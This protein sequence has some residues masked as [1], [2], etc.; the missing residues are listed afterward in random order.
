MQNVLKTVTDSRLTAYVIW[1]PIFGGNFN[2]AAK[3]MA[4]R[5]ADK[6]VSYYKDP[7][8]LVGTLWEQVLKTG[9]EIAWDVYLLYDAE[10]KWEK[11]LPQPDFW[12]HQLGG[13]TIAPRLDEEKF[14]EEVKG[15]LTKLDKKA[16]NKEKE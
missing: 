8:S 4:S 13:V 7:N 15:L 16:S 5:L 10:A 1:D 9:R 14:M 12:M 3:N 11:E 6:R 2:R